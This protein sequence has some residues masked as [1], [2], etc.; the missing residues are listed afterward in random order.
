MLKMEICMDDEK[1]IRERKYR[2]VAIYAAIDKLFKKWNFE[3]EKNHAGSV[4][5][6]DNGDD[7]DFGRFCS[8]VN[9]LKK[10]DWFM[11]NVMIWILYDSDD[12]DSPNDFVTEDLLKHYTRKKAMGV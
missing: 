10:Q 11:G 7:R 12:S 6:K 1:I 8:I 9:A 3:G 2:L 4:I 5:Y